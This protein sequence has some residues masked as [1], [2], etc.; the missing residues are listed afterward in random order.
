MGPSPLL[1]LWFSPAV[2]AHRTPTAASCG[3]PP[4]PLNVSTPNALIIGDSISMGFGVSASDTGYGYG[5][6]VRKMLAGPFTE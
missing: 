3:A 1:L 6:N 2:V 5:L 4:Q